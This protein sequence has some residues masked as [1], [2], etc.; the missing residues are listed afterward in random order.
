MDEGKDNQ[1][2]QE[3]IERIGQSTLSELGLEGLPEADKAD[4]LTQLTEIVQARLSERVIDLMSDEELAGFNKLL[5]EKGDE[6]ATAYVLE[7]VPNYEAL[8]LEEYR[9]LVNEVQTQQGEV[10]NVLE[11]RRQQDQS[12][13]A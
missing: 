10:I 5:D 11:K 3:I 2:N 12:A 4:L 13:D 6:A 7:I 9:K 1:N 8:A